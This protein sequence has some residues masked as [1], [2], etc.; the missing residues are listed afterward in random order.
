MQF[1][2]RTSSHISESASW[3]IL[4]HS[5]PPEWIIREP[6]ERDYGVDYYVEIVRH[7]NQVTGE[8]CILQLKSSKCVK[9]KKTQSTMGRKARFKG[10]KKSTVNYWMG[11]P[12]PVFLMW[13]EVDTGKMYFASVKEQV[14]AQFPAYRDQKQNTI[15]FDFYSDLC[16]DGARGEQLFLVHYHVERL[17]ER[18]ASCLAGL[19]IHHGEYYQFI[20]ENQ[21]R[22][23]FLEV[24]EERQLLLRHIYET[25]VFLSTFL[26]VQWKV[27]DLAE[28]YRL[29]R[30]K[31]KDS[32][33]M[34][35]EKTLHEILVQLKPVFIR[36]LEK[37][38]EL[39]IEEQKGYWI[40][41]D[42]LLYIMCENL[43]IDYMK[44][45]S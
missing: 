15:G 42:W 4:Q 24:E 12:V 5:L 34:M 1:P 18:F 9:W 6:T 16:M 41:N 35:H 19:L 32:Y 27:I 36:I 37:A 20:I 13:A 29:D 7:N 8:L 31:W 17:Y 23:C 33:C 28:A 39:I 38:R 44:R 26:R 45:E 25:C 40:E 3:K 21:N 22:D 43:C 10:I 11:L 30:E 14:R 2:N